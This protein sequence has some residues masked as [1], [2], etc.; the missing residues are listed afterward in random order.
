MILFWLVTL[1]WA[2]ELADLLLFR[3]TLD[4]FGI[5]PRRVDWLWGILFAPFLHGGLGHLVANTSS[6]LFLGWLVLLRRLGNFLVVTV[7][8]ILTSGLG[9]WL[10]GRPNSVHIGASGLVF[11][12]LGYLLLRGYFER[13]VTSIVLSVVVGLLYGGALSGVLPG[14]PGISWEGHLF[15][16]LGGVA[17]ARLL[18][19]PRP[20]RSW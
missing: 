14:V 10:F 1:L 9:V 19:Q 16:F 17:A 18:A 3:G 20:R 2:L 7:L 12:Y 8:A 15:G 4:G 13:R 5:W 11:G 6:L